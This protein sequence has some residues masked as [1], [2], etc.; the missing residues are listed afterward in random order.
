MTTLTIAGPVAKIA[1]GMDL[2]ELT[3]A[4]AVLEVN[5]SAV[6]TDVNGNP[7][8]D[9]T[10]VNFSVV[11]IE[12]DEDRANDETLDCWDLN[13]NPITCATYYTADPTNPVILIAGLGETWFT[14]DVNL[15]GTVGTYLNPEYAITEDING[16]DILDSG[17][18]INGNGIIDPIGSCVISS[19]V[20][21]QSGVATSVMSYPQPHANNIKIRITA[22]SGGVSNFYE[23]I[24]LCTET[25]VDNGVC[26]IDY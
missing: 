9:S 19:S 17:E 14:D 23:S 21:T 10:K 16:N 1:V 13:E 26:G 5:V 24:L 11:S 20:E 15:N 12:F 7:V 2:H 3:A 8:P 25:M 18:D 4:G 6:A 22:E